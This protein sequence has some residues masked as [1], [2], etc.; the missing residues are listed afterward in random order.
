MKGQNL[1]TKRNNAATESLCACKMA[2]DPTFFGILV[3]LEARTHVHLRACV[4]ARLF[5][6]ALTLNGTE[7]RAKGRRGARTQIGRVP[8][9]LQARGC[10]HRDLVDEICNTNAAQQL[11]DHLDVE[12]ATKTRRSLSFL[13]LLNIHTFKSCQLF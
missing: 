11:L 1:E 9:L 8:P 3:F 2:R 13:A 7:T 5:R 6:T 10:L 4:R 12:K